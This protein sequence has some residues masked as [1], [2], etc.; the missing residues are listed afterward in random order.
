MRKNPNHHNQPSQKR[1][2]RPPLLPKP[3]Q[4][5]HPQANPAVA[6]RTIFI[7]PIPPRYAVLKY[8][9]ALAWTNQ[10]RSKP[11][12]ATSN[13]AVGA[14]DNAVEGAMIIAEVKVAIETNKANK[15]ARRAVG[16]NKIAP[17]RPAGR[18]EANSS[19][20]AVAATPIATSANAKKYNSPSM[21]LH[22]K[23]H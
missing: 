14:M 11:T 9:G 13:A 19:P 23:Q 21:L 5:H 18:Q 15:T 6:Q 17:L 20:V 8:L 1:L 3:N 10:S 12:K 22:C 7:A 4:H 2:R 16:S